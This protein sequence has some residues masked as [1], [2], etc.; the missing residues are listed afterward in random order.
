MFESTAAY[1]TGSLTITS[2]GGMGLKGKLLHSW[3]HQSRSSIP[4]QAAP[5]H[6]QEHDFHRQ[7]D[8]GKSNQLVQN[9][10]L[11]TGK[12]WQGA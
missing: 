8:T 2:Y 12:M 11:D 3:K 1:Q 9:V 10:Q 7:V 5:P 4:W 6:T